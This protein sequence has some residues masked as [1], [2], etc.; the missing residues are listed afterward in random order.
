MDFVATERELREV[1]E[2]QRELCRQYAIH[3][4]EF[5]RASWE[6]M[7]LLVPNQRHDHFRK[8]SYEKQIL[9]LL[10]D[11]PENHKEE[12]YGLVKQMKLSREKYKGLERLI[13][14]AAGRI[15]SV[16]SLLRFARSND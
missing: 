1:S 14:Q 15:S 8:A 9:M 7:V 4:Q 6:V 16:Q 12:V 10:A 5:G 11:T 2:H 13:E 3:R